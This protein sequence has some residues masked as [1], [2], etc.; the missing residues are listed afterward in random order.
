MSTNKR[1]QRTG[2]KSDKRTIGNVCLSI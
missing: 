2:E 1:T